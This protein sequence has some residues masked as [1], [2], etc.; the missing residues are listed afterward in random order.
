MCSVLIWK[1][2]DPAC[3]TIY[4][5]EAKPER[6]PRLKF[7]CLLEAIPQYQFFRSDIFSLDCQRVWEEN[8]Q[9]LFIIN[10]LWKIRNTNVLTF[11]TWFNTNTSA[12][13][14][15]LVKQSWVLKSLPAI[16]ERVGVKHHAHIY[17]FTFNI[18]SF[19]V[20]LVFLF[21]R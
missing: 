3:C 8:V 18:Y 16:L 5:F 21:S 14:C 9:I 2:A 17:Q 6:K 11:I 13:H 20:A 7:R 10:F 15:P 12:L 1:H 19:S 4:V